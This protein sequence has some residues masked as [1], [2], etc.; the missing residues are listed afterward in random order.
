MSLPGSVAKYLMSRL[1]LLATFSNR[2]SDVIKVCDV[3]NL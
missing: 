2:F 1:K 3:T